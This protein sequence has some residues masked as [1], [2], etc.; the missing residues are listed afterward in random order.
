[1]S[2]YCALRKGN[3]S[4]VVKTE[5]VGLYLVETKP[6]VE[7]KIRMLDMTDAEYAK[8]PGTVYSDALAKALGIF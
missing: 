6:D 2:K 8:I 4:T 3:W 1:M 5:H 7:L